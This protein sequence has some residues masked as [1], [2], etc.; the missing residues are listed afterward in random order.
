MGAASGGR[1]TFSLVALAVLMASGA[2]G[3]VIVGG[4]PG[5]PAGGGPTTTTMVGSSGPRPGSRPS[6][7]S[8]ATGLAAAAGTTSDGRTGGGASPPATGSADRYNVGAAHSPALLE[9]LAGPLSRT[10]LAAPALTASTPAASTPAKGVDVAAD[11]HPG[12]API[13]WRQVA[14]AGYTFAAVK[15]TEGDYYANPWYAGDASGAEAAGLAVT[16]YHFAIPNESGGAAQADFA[17]SHLG[18]TAAGQAR[19]LAVDLEYDPYTGT[20][21][22]N[23]CYGRSAR[24]L[25]SWI[26]AFTSEAQRLTGRIPVIYTTAAWWSACTGDSA[27]FSAV[28]LW[29]AGYGS[30]RPGG[31]AAW[32]SWT[33]WQFTSVATVPGIAAGAATDVSYARASSARPGQTRPFTPAA[34]RSAPGPF[35]PAVQRAAPAP[36]AIAPRAAVSPAAVSP[37]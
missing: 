3:I 14:A 1:L 13:D 2:T 26:A 23:P 5:H 36:A 6:S 27:G 11:Q 15:A 8:P 16:G 9:E 37:A 25:V 35:A 19:P 21:H 31:P 28:P 32:P 4:G 30:G 12:G 29:V 22:T 7:S 18:D 34:Q 20:D 33:Y 17:V 10:G 24:Q